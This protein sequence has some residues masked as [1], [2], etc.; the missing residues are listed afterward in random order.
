[1]CRG[2]FVTWNRL[3][4]ELGRP[5]TQALL[6]DADRR[7]RRLK[8]VLLFGDPPDRVSFEIVSELLRLGRWIRPLDNRRNRL[9][10]QGKLLSGNHFGSP[11]RIRHDWAI[12]LKQPPLPRHRLPL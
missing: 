5:V 10:A 9:L 11:A 2:V 3:R 7:R 12:A 6:T 1:M 8:S 4:S